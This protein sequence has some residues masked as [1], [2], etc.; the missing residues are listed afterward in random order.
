MAKNTIKGK[1]KQ[2]FLVGDEGPDVSK[3]RHGSENTQGLLY[4]F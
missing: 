4:K 1:P 3:E 2:D